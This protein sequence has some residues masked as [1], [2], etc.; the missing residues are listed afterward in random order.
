MK[1]EI[2][3]TAPYNTY[4]EDLYITGEGDY[5]GK[6]ATP[7][8]KMKRV[9]H[10]LYSFDYRGEL[11]EFE[12]KVT[13]GSWESEAAQ[14]SGNPLENFK[15]SLK[16]SDKFVAHIKNWKDRG[17]LFTQSDRIDVYENFF[18]IELNNSRKVSVYLPPSYHTNTNNSYPVIYMHDGENV[19]DPASSSYGSDWAADKVA[20]NLIDRNEIPEVIIV[21]I[22]SKNRYEEYSPYRLGKK[23]EEFLIHT[24]LPFIENNYRT[25]QGAHSRYLVGSS[26]G[27]IITLM[28]QWD[29]SELFAKAAGLSFPAF[30]HNHAIE[31][32][33]SKNKAPKGEFFFYMDH[34]DWGIDSKYGQS[35]EPFYKRLNKKLKT[36]QSVQY[37]V[38]PYSD[39]SESYWASRLDHIFKILLN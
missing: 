14:E 34:G 38:F 28:I 39:H 15:Y 6:W 18:S 10:H 20:S 4:H 27:A 16:E 33:I 19:F 9:G 30:I 7:G 1:K 32:Y 35:A 11:S 24:V 25:Q 12:F 13:R 3:I 17:A 21:A 2:I 23:Y 22:E 29:Y 5:L 31:H 37:E 36:S 8:I 26:M